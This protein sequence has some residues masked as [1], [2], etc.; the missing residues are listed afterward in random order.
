MS[1][2]STGLSDCEPGDFSPA[3]DRIAGAKAIAAFLGIN[4]R[5]CRYRLDRDLIPHAK[6]GSLH[7][8]SKAALVAHWRKV[9]GGTT[10]AA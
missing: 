4:E 1:Q 5:Q 3:K 7:V 10:E 6:E 2:H 9:T 8:A